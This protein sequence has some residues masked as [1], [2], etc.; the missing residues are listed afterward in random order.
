MLDR[1][2]VHL[3]A[4]GGELG[5]PGATLIINDRLRTSAAGGAARAQQLA[6]TIIDRQL[7]L[8]GTRRFDQP[9]KSP[10]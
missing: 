10:R 6:K 3:I 5:D 9:G 4:F 1:A 8:D 7:Q 2:E